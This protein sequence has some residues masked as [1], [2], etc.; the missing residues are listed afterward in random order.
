MSAKHIL[1][2]DR[3]STESLSLVQRQ[4]HFQ[5]YKCNPDQLLS[6]GDLAKAHAL[7]IRSRTQITQ[8]VLEKAKNLQLII[9]ATSGFDHIDLELTQKWGVTVMHT[10]DA[11]KESAAQLTLT[12]LLCL[13]QKVNLASKAI[14]AGHWRQEDLLGMELS[15]RT[16]G[17]VGLGRIGARVSDLAKAFNMPVIA[18][19]PYQTEEQFE[20]C[21]A[22]RVSFEEL[23]KLSDVISFHVPKT[24]ETFRMLHRPQFEII[25]R[26]AFLIN[27][28]RGHVIDEESLIHAL[29]KKWIKGLA[30][31]VYEK[32]PLARNSRLL[33]FP[34]V[35]LTPH[36]GAFTED[37]FYKASHE[38]VLKLIQF[39][40]DGSTKD[41]LPPRAP[42]YGAL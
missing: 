10:P 2:T 8:E 15:G 3:F 25:H 28:S 5:I 17:I 12:L 41:T 20:K 36:I 26:E 38:A 24:P 1:I 13:A 37:A 39:F 18:Y 23:L 34:E 29:E 7:L 14:R 33:N 4:S 22:K 40:I 16:W 19:D 9:T 11:N 31:D 35:I 27:T 21:S 6:S 32:E 30:L 42:W